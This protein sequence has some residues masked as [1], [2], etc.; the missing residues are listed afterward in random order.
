VDTLKTTVTPYKT[1]L[2]RLPTIKRTLRSLAQ[3]LD[4]KPATQPRPLPLR[5]AGARHL[6]FGA[7]PI[8]EGKGPGEPPATW[9]GAF[10]GG[11]SRDEWI[12][13]WGLWKKL[14]IP[15][16]PR[17]SDFTGGSKGDQGF[18]YQEDFAGGRL[19]RGGAVVDF[20]VNFR[21]RI[22]AIRLMTERYHAAAKREQQVRDMRGKIEIAKYQRVCDLWSQNF[23][24]DPTG[25]AV[26]ANIAAC[27]TGAEPPD[28]FNWSFRRV[29][30]PKKRAA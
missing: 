9:A 22:I 17:N 15:G 5:T 1:N 11:A 3:P 18:K 19:K 24:A 7:E 14:R 2:G 30:P 27:L 4:T 29:R 26:C 21:D 20:E 13:Y 23:L 28:P 16:D 8:L 25:E 6:N 12:V 10:P